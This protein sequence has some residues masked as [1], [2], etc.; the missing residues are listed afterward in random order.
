VTA[1]YWLI[2]CDNTV[3][4][5]FVADTADAS[6]DASALS[7]G[8]PIESWSEVAWLKAAKPEDDGDPDDALQNHLGL[9]IFSPVLHEEL[10][11]ADVRGFQYLPVRIIRP[12]GRV[13]GTFSIANIVECREALNMSRSN[14]DVFPDDYF[15]PERRGRVRGILSATL[16]ADALRDCDVVR[17]KEFPFSIYVSQRFKDTFELGEFTGLSFVKV[18][19]S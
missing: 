2:Q 12:D 19:L 4:D 8:K 9:P 3:D 13:L 10:M 6:I 16:I 14:Y 17:L 15:L 11:R 18:G 7:S 5:P 1:W